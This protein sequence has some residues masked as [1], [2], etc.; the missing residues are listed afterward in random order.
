MNLPL[1]VDKLDKY[2]KCI[3][4]LRRG[5]LKKISKNRAIKKAKTFF[6]SIILFYKPSTTF[7]KFRWPVKIV[8]LRECKKNR[9]N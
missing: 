3:K 1:K 7:K 8:E 5:N 2:D 4:K 6:Y 9:K